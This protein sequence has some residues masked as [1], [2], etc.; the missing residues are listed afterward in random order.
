MADTKRAR[1]SESPPSK[2]FRVLSLSISCIAFA[3]VVFR[4][5]DVWQSLNIIGVSYVTTFF[6][7]VSLLLLGH[8]VF[9]LLSHM[10]RTRKDETINKANWYRAY[11]SRFPFADNACALVAFVATSTCF[12][13]NK[14][15]VIGTEGFQ[16]DDLFIQWD[17][18]LF[19]GR[20]PWELTHRLLPTAALTK[21][22][23]LLY[24]PLFIPM[25]VG[26]IL[27]F[28][29]RARAD[30]RYT[31]MLTY[32]ASFVIIGMMMA[33]TLSS[34]GP[35]F[36][37]DLVGDEAVFAPLLDRLD[38]QS[39]AAGPFTSILARNY[40]LALHLNGEA[41]FF[42]GISA[43]PSMHIALAYMWAFAAWQI[44]RPLGVVVHVYAAVIWIGSVHLGWHYFVDGLVSL[45]VLTVIWRILGRAMGLYQ[46]P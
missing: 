26:Y 8:F 19:L 36:Y 45:I 16:Y 32:L 24:H 31:Y 14:V 22:I 29:T 21:W 5:D 35:V 3:L 15:K 25:V 2:W 11:W 34:A 28:S 33:T 38:L 37:G 12:S 6:I 4:A 9:S 30:L 17:R 39:E 18:V 23:D 42:G 40:L 43:M 10:L 7:F 44:N 41:R 27:C 13:A 46:K 1:N 20:A